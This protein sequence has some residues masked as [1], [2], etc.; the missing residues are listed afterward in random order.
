[1]LDFD[2]YQAHAAETA[3]YPDNVKIIYPAMGLAGEVGEVLNKIK[4]IYR[5]E[6]GQL[7]DAKREELAKEVGDCL[8]YVAALCTDLDISMG[9]AAEGNFRKLIDR[10]NRGVIGGSGDNR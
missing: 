1:M 5:D 4:K 2:T 8:W 7:S 10:M 9:N 6:Q 3:I